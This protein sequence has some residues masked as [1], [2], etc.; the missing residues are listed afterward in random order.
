MPQQVFGLLH[1]IL[2]EQRR[3]RGKY[4]QV[5]DQRHFREIAVAA[6]TPVNR[7]IDAEIV[8]VHQVHADR[9]SE[10]ELGKPTGE[11]AKVAD[12]ACGCEVGADMQKQ[13]GCGACP[14]DQCHAFRDL[15]ESPPH[16]FHQHLSGF[17]CCHAA[18][19]T[20]E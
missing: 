11:M 2:L 4:L 12:Q 1:W 3:G 14:L 19:V 9:H 8:E 15:V 7:G 6:I 16:I 20:I 10:I 5:L 17:R 18:H 13:L